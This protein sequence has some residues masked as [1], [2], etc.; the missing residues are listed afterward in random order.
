MGVRYP[1]VLV[2][3]T[4]EYPEAAHLEGDPEAYSVENP[5]ATSLLERVRCALQEGGASEE[6]IEA[7]TR[8]ATS[9]CYNHLLFTT[10]MWMRTHWETPSF[11]TAEP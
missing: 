4:G 9:R 7:Y 5:R 3:I 1:D 6:E 8:E 10:M 11:A 2:W